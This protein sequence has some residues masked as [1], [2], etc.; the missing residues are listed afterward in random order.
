M[1]Q[2]DVDGVY[3]II[4]KRANRC[5]ICKKIIRDWNQSGLCSACHSIINLKKRRKIND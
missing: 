1:A 5:S 4:P 2:K 3:E